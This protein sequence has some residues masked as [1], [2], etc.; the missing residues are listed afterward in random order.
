MRRWHRGDTVYEPKLSTRDIQA[1][2]RL[3][4]AEWRKGEDLYAAVSRK[5]ATA[6][7][8]PSAPGKPAIAARQ[9]AAVQ[10]AVINDELPTDDQTVLVSD[11]PVPA[12]SVQPAVLSTRVYTAPDK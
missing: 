12:Q 6:N 9:A 5:P 8:V 11:V 10:P 4:S 3:Y 7:A 1:I 2:R